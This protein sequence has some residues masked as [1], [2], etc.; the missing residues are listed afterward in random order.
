MCLFLESIRIDHGQP[1]NLMAHQQRM[2]VAM[3]HFF[4]Q[5]NAFSLEDLVVKQLADPQN[6]FLKQ[7][8]YK[9]RLVYSLQPEEVGFVAYL[10][11]KI[12]S[13]QCV[14]DDGVK[15]DYKFADRSGL[16]ALYGRRG[17]ADDI[18]MVKNGLITDSSYA[19]VAFFD[20]TRWFTPQLP[21]LAGTRR[22]LLLAQNI[23]SPTNISPKELC[24]YQ[25][26]RLFNAMIRWE[27]AI[28]LDVSNIFL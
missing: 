10:L 28:E 20:G 2:D 23:I 21:L 25:K 17:Q 8:L 19:N 26:I 7:G 6:E 12:R 22:A 14:D 16:E 3:R 24:N 1:E 11:P 9:M 15:Y 4:G 5:R 27:D 18:L 13:L